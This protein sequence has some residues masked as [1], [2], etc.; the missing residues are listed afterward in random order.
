[1]SLNWDYEIGGRMRL[2]VTGGGTGGHVYPAIAIC[3]KVKQAIPDCEILYVGSKYGIENKILKQYDIKYEAINVRGFDRRNI[4]KAIKAFFLLFYA[5][6]ESYVIVKKFKPDLVI[7][8]GGYVCGPVVWMANM[9]K[10]DSFIHEQNSVPGLTIGFLAKRAKRVLVSYKSSMKYF[11]KQDNLFYTGNPVR[12]E[13][14]HLDRESARQKLGIFGNQKLILSFGGSNGANI[15][16]KSAKTLI[17]FVKARN[18]IKYIHITGNSAYDDFVG[19]CDCTG[20]ENITVM[21]YADNMPELLCAADL[22]IC[23][24]GAMTLAEI[25]VCHLPAILIPSPY[26]AHNHQYHNAE[27]FSEARCSV[28]IEENQQTVDHVMEQIKRLTDNEEELLQMRNNYESIVSE[29]PL[30]SIMAMIYDYNIK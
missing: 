13:F 7:G 5:F 17:E 27:V 21:R 14:Y 20:F 29:N 3:E 11:K 10:V 2:I 26:V 1:M 12:S 25:A 19:D 24:A 4:F 28:L 30:N 16:N 15:I 8:M 6:Y 23:R 22:C 9:Q 18:D